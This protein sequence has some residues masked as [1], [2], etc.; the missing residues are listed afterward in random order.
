MS[1]NRSPELGRFVGFGLVNIDLI[2]VVPTWERD[3]KV[4]ASQWIE[5]LGGPVPVALCAAARLAPA[6]CPA[7]IGTVGSD[8]FADAVAQ[9]LS[10]FGVEHCLQRRPGG[11]TGRSMVFLDQRDGSRT[12][13]HWSESASS[14]VFDAHELQLFRDAELVHV[15]GRDF[16]AT[17][18]CLKAAKSGNATTSWDLGTMRPGREAFYP[19]VDIV[20]ASRGG[21]AGAFPDVRDN[22]VEQVRRF[23]VAGA[24]V[25]AV[26]LAEKGVAVGWAGH[27]PLILPAIPTPDVVDTCGAG[28]TFHGSFLAAH[29]MGADPVEATMIA[30]AAVSL[31]IRS[32]GHRAGLPTRPDVDQLLATL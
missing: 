16:D 6:T 19:L 21:G 2:A 29:L 27:E 26:T 25:A 17:L 20:I 7:F 4:D 23:L 5:Q 24:A 14:R 28:D 32:Y 15:D 12:L 22:P 1:P 8:P 11:K 13:S 30:Q 3:R 9:D 10:F 31:R 18:E